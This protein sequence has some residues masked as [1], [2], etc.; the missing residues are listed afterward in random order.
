MKIFSVSM[1]VKEIKRNGN[2]VITDNVVDYFIQEKPNDVKTLKNIKIDLKKKCEKANVIGYY[3]KFTWEVS[4]AYHNL[5]ETN[6]LNIFCNKL[7]T[8]TK[9]DYA[10]NSL[11]EASEI[12]KILDETSFV[13][14]AIL[15]LSFKNYKLSQD[16]NVDLIQRIVINE[17]LPQ[18]TIEEAPV[19][20][21]L[22]PAIEE[23]RYCCSI[24]E[25][26]RYLALSPNV[27]LIAL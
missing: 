12:A 8:I 9:E 10:C 24:K 16:C 17:N 26:E 18:K 19:K 3:S 4:V 11:G 15:K 5:T 20:S 22:I 27:P 7:F 1:T 25:L 13:L 6:K 21:I 14:P 2:V 23:K